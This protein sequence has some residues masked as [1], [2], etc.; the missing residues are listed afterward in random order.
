MGCRR[1]AKREVPGRLLKLHAG[2]DGL[3]SARL[4]AAGAKGQ[5]QAEQ[6]DKKTPPHAAMTSLIAGASVITG[7]DAFR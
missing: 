2:G 6:G 4:S 5:P 7:N 3:W 1:E